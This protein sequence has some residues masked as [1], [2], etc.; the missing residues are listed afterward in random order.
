MVR[1]AFILGLSLCCSCLYA[2]EKKD[3]ITSLKVDKP[4]QGKVRIFQDPKIEALLK[5]VTAEVVSTGDKNIIK[6][7]G[8][9]IQ[10]FAGNNTREARNRAISIGEQVAKL[11]PELAVYTPFVSPR[12]ICRV[13]DFRSIEEADAM[14][15]KLRA[16]NKFKEVSIVR[17]QI[18]IPLD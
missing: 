16:T 3:I 2:Q 17:E 18:V 9:R 7:T 12:W 4:G 5:S 15:R 1:K 13:G 14:L 8:Y 10:V 6:A 11:F